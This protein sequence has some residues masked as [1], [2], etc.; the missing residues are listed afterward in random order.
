MNNPLKTIDKIHTRLEE[1]NAYYYGY[2]GDVVF[3]FNQTF[4]V[5][6]L[7]SVV[8]LSDLKVLLK[9]NF[10]WL[11]PLINAPH[12]DSF[13]IPK[14]SGGMRKIE[15]PEVLLR[16][17]QA[18]F[19]FYLQHYY[20]LVRP[21]GVFGF[22]INPNKKES[23]CNIVEN[24]K[25]HVHKKYVLNLDL[26]DFFSSI[27]AYRV[28]ALF[29][30]EYFRYTEEVANAL[31]LLVTYNGTLPTGAPTSP[32]ISNFICLQLDA[33]L[34]AYCNENALHYSRYADDLTFSS[35]REITTLHLEELS[36]IIHSNHFTINSK[37]TRLRL[38]HRKQTVTG[39]IVNEKVNV[40][41]KTIK[42]VRAMLYDALQNGV[43]K[44]AKKHFSITK[45]TSQMSDTYFLNRLEGYIN[46]IAQVRGKE[47]AMVQ[48]FKEEFKMVHLLS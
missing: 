21:E 48:K 1:Y 2:Q 38:H 22:V 43:S 28:K 39:L 41:R 10:S 6:Q 23:F 27:K 18:R 36:K 24:A 7:L 17:T 35:D 3:K 26:E 34:L 44:A 15:A 9:L 12:Y 16:A 30:S 13:S 20:H 19:N 4:F 40:D 14:K 45:E 32:V 5:Q 37:K 11:G 29:Q 47:D 8:K 25:L 33:M 42:M 31:A 46:F